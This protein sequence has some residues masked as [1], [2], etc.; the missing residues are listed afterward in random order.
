[1]S[2]GERRQ[3]KGRVADGHGGSRSRLPIKSRLTNGTF[4]P[5]TIRILTGAFE[6]AWQ[7]LNGGGIGIG[8]QTDEMRDALAKSIIHVALQ[9]ERDQRRLRDSALAHLASS[10]GDG[11]PRP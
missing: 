8:P 2:W 10:M 3:G 5:D 6:D 11:A 7:S 1:M 4:D 9:G